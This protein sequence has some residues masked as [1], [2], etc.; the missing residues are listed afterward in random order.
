MD[1]KSHLPKRLMVGNDFLTSY[2]ILYHIIVILYSLNVTL[3]YIR[4]YFTM[5]YYFY[6]ILCYVIL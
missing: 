3:Y 2:S 5:A 6:I 1:G 4:L